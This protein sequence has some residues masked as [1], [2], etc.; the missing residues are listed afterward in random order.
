MHSAPPGTRSGHDP[1][2]LA[3]AGL[4]RLVE[5]TD[6]TAMLLL[7]ALGPVAAL[8]IAT[9]TRPIG[10]GEHPVFVRAAAEAGYGPRQVD[11]RRA[12]ARWAPRAADLDPSADLGI[13]A[14]AGAWFAIPEDPDWPAA[15]ADL[16][17]FQPV[18]LWGRGDRR[19]LGFPAARS[20]AVVGSRDCST[21]GRQVAL[22]IAGALAARGWTVVSGG[23]HGIDQAAH[24]AALATGTAHP[25][26][27]S[28]MAC[29]IDRLYP[30]GNH[31]LLHRVEAAGLLLAE[32]APGCTPSR[33]RFLQ[34]NRII[35]ALS[36][37]T[38]VVEARWRSGAQ[39]TAHHADGLSRP[40][41]AVPGSVHAGTSA[42]C[43]R[44]VREG[45]AVLVTDV[46]EVLELVQ[47]L[48]TAPAPDRPAPAS[49]VDGLSD[50]D[51]VLLDALPMRVRSRPDHLSRVAGLSAREVL[52]GLRR[53]EGRGLAEGAGE[54]WRRR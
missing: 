37:G 40:V 44:L 42:G 30:P 48:G 31:E 23:A 4:S 27:V 53:L 29:G 49:V 32:A 7:A 52:G 24:S 26:T 28:V 46:D 25:P 1:L 33:Y 22:D 5:P 19:L 6:A 3:R 21:Y 45:T 11:L 43:H 41:G 17:L 39:N 8:E 15:L 38:V 9:G 34:R 2:L 14:R 50:R 13:A 10:A 18:G 16:G 36:A 20:V 12:L 35:A 47:P 54:G 51:R